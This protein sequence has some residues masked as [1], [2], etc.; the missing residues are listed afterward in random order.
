[1][2]DLTVP[3][4]H[5]RVGDAERERVAGLLA[6]HH[7]AGRLTVA[8]LDERLTA[9]LSARTRDELTAP[10]ADLPAAPRTP[11]PAVPRRSPADVGWRMHL[12]SYLAVIVGLWL[13]WALTGAGYPW[14]IWPMLG[15]GL[16]L[17]GHR[18]QLG[19]CG[20]VRTSTPG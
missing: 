11:A 9:T 15:W 20:R 17:I 8:E 16:G 6:E 1:M 3:S 13:I 4:G 12:T 2:S 18:G 5:L 14:P 10:L 19:L 7:A